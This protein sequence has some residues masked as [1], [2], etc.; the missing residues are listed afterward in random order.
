[1]NHIKQNYLK[2]CSDIAETAMR[3]RRKREEIELVAVSKGHSLEEILPVYEAG[4][5]SFGESRI[6]DALPKIAS[7]PSDIHWHFIGTLQKNKVR[8][9][10]D[11]FSL[12]HSVDT[13]ELGC[14]ISEC[15]QELKRTVPVLL[16]VNTSAETSKHG[17]SAKMLLEH[18]ETLFQYP[19]IKIEGL[20][21]MAPLTDNEKIIRSCFSS[22]RILKEKLNAQL[23]T[24]QLHTLSMG[25][26]QDYKL[27]I[28]EGATLLR[29]GT[30]IF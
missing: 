27:A 28:E 24:N 4:C 10:M 25:M 2:I 22:L 20:M 9:V 11:H 30:L 15:A 14:K 26:S 29:I 21:T 17:F 3:A 19:G 1:M 5:R 6:S 18:F 16:Q 8:R 13:L 12:I 23:G 7:G